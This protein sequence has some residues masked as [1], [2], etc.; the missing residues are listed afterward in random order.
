VLRIVNKIVGAVGRRVDESS[1]MVDARLLDGS[2][3]NVAIRPIAIDGPLV[4]IRK[5]AKR[6]LNMDA[7][8][9]NGALSTTM[10]KVLAEAVRARLSIVIRHGQRKTTFLNALPLTQQ[11]APHHHRGCRAAAQQPHVGR[12]ETRPPNMEDAARSAARAGQERAQMRPDRIIVGEVRGEEAFD[13]LQAMTTG[14][15]GSMTTVHANSPRDAISRMEQMVGMAGFPMSEG[16]IR[17]QIA[18]AIRI[19]VQLQRF[20]DGKRR[21]TSISEITG[22][23]GS[24][25]QMQELRSSATCRAES[26]SHRI[27][28]GV[29]G[30]FLRSWRGAAAPCSTR[31]CERWVTASTLGTGAVARRTDPIFAYY[32]AL[33]AVFCPSWG[34]RRRGIGQQ[35]ALDRRYADRAASEPVKIRRDAGLPNGESSCAATGSIAS[36]CNRAHPGVAALWLARLRERGTFLA[37]YLVRQLSTAVV[38]GLLGGAGLVYV[39]LMRLRAARQ[40]KLEAQLPEAIDILVRSLK[41]GHPILAAVRLVRHELPDPIGSEFG[42]L[43]DEITYG[44]DLESAMNNLATRVG[45]EDLTLVVI[46]AGI[47][48]STGG[49][50]AEILGG[51]SHIVRER[52]KMRLKVKAMSAEGRFSA[53][54]LSALPFALFAILSLIAPTFYGEVWDQPIVKPVLFAAAVWLMIGNAVMHRMV[55][56]RI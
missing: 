7:L 19:I 41:A 23:D 50:L 17:S 38:G 2:R 40:R 15:E 18:S 43:A 14:H 25:V 54:M 56:F 11:G 53:I 12:P 37:M 45:Q 47:Q 16:S 42:I 9:K 29:R 51:M 5:F 4:S 33:E 22:M 52:L 8:V 31:G 10:A 39:T 35:A 3:I 13:M 20:A 46:A 55:R 30:R 48:A 44:L 26:F 28:T 1:P 24:V 32:L 36:S 6:A 49:N 27:A 21:V 34:G